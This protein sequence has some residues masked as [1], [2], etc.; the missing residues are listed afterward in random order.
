[1]A[2]QPITL[3]LDSGPDMDAT[4][5]DLVVSAE[6]SIV[7]EAYVFTTLVGG[8]GPP[9]TGP[10]TVVN[11]IVSN[12]SVDVTYLDEGTGTLYVSFETGVTVYPDGSVAVPSSAGF[13]VYVLAH[14]SPVTEAAA[15]SLVANGTYDPS[16]TGIVPSS[17]EQ[18]TTVVTSS[19][20][21]PG[22]YYDFSIHAYDAVND[23]IT[24]VLASGTTTVD[25]LITDIS[26][27]NK[28]TEADLTLETTDPDSAVR[29]LAAV[30]TQPYG[31]GKT[32]A[33]VRADLL[34]ETYSDPT[35][36]FETV[37]GIG[38]V[39]SVPTFSNLS[40]NAVYTAVVLAVDVTTSN[41]TECN[42]NFFTFNEPEVTSLTEVTALRTYDGLTATADVKFSMDDVDLV[43]AIVPDTPADINAF[44]AA[45][46]DPIGNI[47][48]VNFPLSGTY[49]DIVFDTTGL[50]PGT[51][52]AAVAKLVPNIQPDEYR[53][54][55]LSL[56]T[57]APP[58]I[59]INTPFVLFFYA[60]VSFEVVDPDDTVNV[61]AAV[62][63]ATDSAPIAVDNL[64]ASGSI[65]YNKAVVAVGR[66]SF[67]DT[68]LRDDLVPDSL[69]RITVAAVESA[70]S[71]LVTYRST[72]FWTLPVP[73]LGLTSGV[74]TDT[75]LQAT[76]TTEG[77]QHN[78]FIHLAPYIVGNTVLYDA[79]AIAATTVSDSNTHVILGA[80]SNLEYPSWSNLTE[81]TQYGIVMIAAQQSDNAVLNEEVIIMKTAALPDATMH[82]LDHTYDDVSYRLVVNDLD[83]SFRIL[84]AVSTQAFTRADAEAFVA[85]GMFYAGSGVVGGTQADYPGDA[86]DSDVEFIYTASNLLTAD[87]AYSAVAV[88]V[89]PDTGIIQWAQ[90]PFLTDFRPLVTI[91]TV[92]PTSHTVAFNITVQDRD[93]PQLTIRYNVYGTSLGITEDLIATDTNALTIVSPGT[94][95]RIITDLEITG[96]TENQTYYLGVVAIS[97]DGSK[98]DVAAPT[99]LFA[100]N[101]DQKPVVGLSLPD[102]TAESIT[103][104][105]DV[106]LAG[107]TYD[108]AVA[109]FPHG[110]T[111]DSNLV[112]DIYLGTASDM[113]SYTL[114]T[115][116][117]GTISQSVIF[118]PLAQGT[119]YTLVGTAVRDDGENDLVWTSI[120]EY[121][122]VE[123]IL[124]VPGALTLTTTEMNTT[125]D[126]TYIDPKP[127]RANSADVVVSVMP[128]GNIDYSWMVAGAS[129]NPYLP[130]VVV[131]DQPGASAYNAIYSTSNLDPLVDYDLVVKADDL[132]LGTSHTVVTPFTSRARVAI[133]PSLVSVTDSDA[134]INVVASLPDGT[135]TLY[136]DAFLDAGGTG[137]P[138]DSWYPIAVSAGTVLGT[139]VS[140][141]GTTNTFASLDSD[142]DYIAVVSA[143]DAVSGERFDSHVAFST[144]AV[145]PTLSIVNGSAV[146][147]STTATLSLLARDI[148]SQFTC[149]A[150]AYPRASADPVDAAVVADVIANPDFTRLFQPSVAQTPFTVT[151]S[152]LSEATDY[153]LV[154]V[155]RDAVTLSNAYD[156]EDF[157][158]IPQEDYLDDLEYDGAYSLTWRRD[159][160]YTKPVRGVQV[161]NGKVAFRTRLDDVL[162]LTDVHLAGNFD[163]NSYGGYTNNLVG[164]FDAYTIGLFDHTL[165]P[166]T[167]SFS[168]SN[169]TLDM[170]TGIVTNVGRFIHPDGIFDVQQDIIALRQMP[171]C[172]LSM[173]RLTSAS[174]IP[175]ARLF[176]EMSNGQGLDAVEYDSTTVYHSSLS[177]SLPVFQAK[178]DVRDS[179]TKMAAA[180]VY[181]FDTA[182]NMDVEHLGFNSFRNIDRAF[183]GYVINNIDAGVTYRFAVLT[184]QATTSDFPRPAQDAVRIVMQVIG[185]QAASSAN[186]YDAAVR[187][188]ASHVSS[189][190][191]AWST[192]V[193]LSPKPSLTVTDTENFAKVK[194]ALRFAQFQL[195]SSVR[196]HGG[197]ELNPLHL[198]SIDTDGNIFWNRELWVVP[199]LLYTKPRVVRAMLENR[200]ESLRAAKTLAGAQGFDGA[201]YPYVSD[202]AAFSASPYWDVAAASYVFNTALVGA[203][204]WDYF[205]ATHDRDWL[206]S[207]GFPMVS[208]IADYVVSVAT[209]SGGVTSFPEVLDV[210][211]DRV[212][213]PSFT[214]YICR[215]ALKAAIEACYELRYPVRQA[216]TATFSGIV[217]AFYLAPDAEVAKHHA[218]AAPSDD[219]RLLE[220]LFMMH[221]HY[222][223]DFL[224]YDVPRTISTDHAT[225]LANY[226]QYTNAMTTE[227][228]DNPFNTLLRMSLLAQINR[229]TGTHEADIDALILKAVEDMGKDVWGAVAADSGSPWN[230]VSL[231]A[232]FVLTFMTSFAGLHV[233]GG[234]AQSGFYYQPMGV[235]AISTS[236]LPEYW[237]SVTVTSGDGVTR[238]IINSALYP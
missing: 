168:L 46:T 230:D 91:G 212:T 173:Y 210:N 83:S 5:A 73:E 141:V 207:K 88:V 211:G 128:S 31:V 164:G 177:L 10:V 105:L 153:R 63:S 233:S 25:P 17:T 97:P 150:K 40:F 218:G 184:A 28:I 197:A 7:D 158:T 56:V 45:N 145:L 162:G 49:N 183:N 228:L 195:F 133:T 125:V 60:T 127:G 139:N 9:S 19:N 214:V 72:F 148:D 172:T 143:V 232:M 170:Q 95:A 80:S 155:A 147:T 43:T 116:Q 190:A 117:T 87:T 132:F 58:N 90:Q 182:S 16:T 171:Y 71:S 237:Q 82:I 129:A 110:V 193:T 175:S 64:I 52:Y 84:S 144:S 198:T 81:H 104:D 32:P 192:S 109:S 229:S 86:G 99:S 238:N 156:F 26:V 103:A 11:E 74:F 42:Y 47:S 59:T 50:S 236:Y 78:L 208:S 76:A 135:F 149:F 92:E 93:G 101:T 161:S 27:F 120:D 201:R 188:R 69:Y 178:A 12:G 3:T 68:I 41:V 29:L 223:A 176:H 138:D 6:S 113:I 166:S 187:L 122:R 159:A 8:G 108:A 131:V 118:S 235:R 23:F 224:R 114:Y 57:A 136:A 37:H 204:A 205:R 191:E 227:Y 102:V 54:S 20:L 96:L 152:A 13:D 53:H 217:P 181:M 231:S 35:G 180:S 140:F 100:F 123:P 61:Y 146:V 65:A 38:T 185:S 226:T 94:G 22:T 36:F 220:P 77:A 98:S 154:A 134:V 115:A 1:M 179:S 130:G 213:D 48:T 216:W 234:V 15:Q 203:A 200:Y 70:N 44:L 222:V 34:A 126:L 151:L 142:K 85:G 206:L 174:N 167:A 4:F 219:L 21:T 24:T 18:I 51:S 209:V 194:R 225:L 62:H 121:T 160:V 67:S 30:T 157:E 124:T 66:S 215:T 14:P 189:W 107:L 79:D 75:S 165:S 2:Q 199:A 221:P 33:D 186:L 163:F 202:V 39:V 106:A 119:H 111:V 137:I 55:V 89:D 112:T 169:Q 196:E